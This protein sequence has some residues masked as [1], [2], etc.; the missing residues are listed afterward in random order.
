VSLA[1]FR[2]VE[3]LSKALHPCHLHADLIWRMARG[4]ESKSVEEQQ[5]GAATSVLHAKPVSPQQNA[6][7]RRREGIELSRERV[8]RELEIAQNPLHQKV[9]QEALA[10]LER[11]LATLEKKTVERESSH[12]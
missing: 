9:L 3:A 6:L 10:H 4:W 1:V 7:R 8:R 2:F 5:N 12:V 11:E